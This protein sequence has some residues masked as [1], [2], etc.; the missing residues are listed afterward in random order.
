MVQIT[1][2]VT[3]QI[4]LDIQTGAKWFSGLTDDEM[5]KFFVAVAAEA[6]SWDGSPGTMWHYVGRHLRTCEC[7]TEP[8]RDLIRGIHYAMERA[9]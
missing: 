4:D 9:P 5:C 2:T 1:T 7:A 8:A 6:E 3:T